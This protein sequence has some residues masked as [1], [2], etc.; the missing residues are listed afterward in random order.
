MQFII[1]VYCAVL[2]LTYM[3]KWHLS[4]IFYA[5]SLNYLQNA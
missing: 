5:V 1:K 2:Y 4:L 3:F